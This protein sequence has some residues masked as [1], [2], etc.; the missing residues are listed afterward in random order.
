[1]ARV[2]II[3]PLLIDTIRASGLA[4]LTIDEV[5]PAI[6]SATDGA[7]TKR[8]TAQ[9]ASELVKKR[10]LARRFEYYIPDG[11]SSPVRRHRYYTPENVR[12]SDGPY[13]LGA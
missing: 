10:L 4:G 1:M 6:E 12:A 8:A 2:S 5:Y 3:D 11:M 13:E 9:R 7:R